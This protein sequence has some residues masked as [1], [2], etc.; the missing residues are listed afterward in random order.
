M[1]APATSPAF[2]DGPGV[3]RLAL[4]AGLG[5]AGG[6]VGVVLPISLILLGS[7]APGG[8]SSFGSMTVEATTILLLAGAILFVLSLVLYHLGFAALRKVDRV[9]TTASVLCIIGTIGFLL[10]LLAAAAL[11]GS[12]SAL[13][14]C[15]HAPR[16]ALQ[17]LNSTSPLGAY[18]AAIGFWMGWLGG[19][20]LVLGLGHAGGRYH[21][22][23]LYGGS[24][25]Y[26]LLVVVVV[27]PFLG[28][29]Y[30]VPDVEYLLL[31]VPLLALLAPGLTLWGALPRTGTSSRL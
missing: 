14:A 22:A 21:R 10:L 18:S 19:V 15:A 3:R 8:L 25:L 31:A 27:G 30:A 23:P 17:C 28:L 26:A 2:R 12:S 5:L 20:G 29:V 13:V 7:L 6:L 1:S 4:G 24:F 11:L 16:S 9:F